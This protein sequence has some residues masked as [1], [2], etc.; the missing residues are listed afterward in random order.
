MGARVRSSRS[1]RL[2]LF[3]LLAFAGTLWALWCVPADARTA[4]VLVLGAH[5][6]VTVRTDSFVGPALPSPH[7]GSS[8][9]PSASAADRNV[10][11]ELAR[12][13]RIRAIT[14]AQYHHYLGSFNSALDAVFHQL[15]GT[16]AAELEAVIENI[17][18]IAASG[19]LWPS[20]LRV[21]FLTLD[22]NHDWW[23]NGPLLDSGQI[24]SFRGSEID[25]EYYPGQGLELQPLASFGKAQ[26]FF[27]NGRRYYRRGAHLMSEL[28]P[29]AANRA[30]GTTW[31]YYFYF[32]GGV[33]PWT[34]AMS[35]GTALQAL[36][37]GY[38][39]LK[40]RSYLSIAHRAL[41]IFSVPPPG[42][43]SVR[44]QLGVRYLLYSFAPGAAVL[45]GFLQ[46]LIGLYDYAHVSRDRL[47]ARLFA[48]GDTEARAEVRNY[49][50]GSW[51][52][53][54]PGEDDSVDYHD[55]VTG[56]LEQLCSYTH[57]R[58]YCVTAAHFRYYAQHPPAWVS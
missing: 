15:D 11:T 26:W 13:Y 41:P 30:G 8:K 58:V 33:P 5:G 24:V 44:T 57:A 46:T 50:T 10:R 45:N 37:D 7:T 1:F 55:L 14:R 42:G 18:G 35:Q 28:V 12:L 31:E 2:R 34:S 27:T 25:W 4:R 53:Y 43:V 51:S 49:D 36:A 29:L 32:D 22:R 16:R 3:S 23:T 48:A 17:H 52:L 20:R 54:Q 38:K 47:A 6:R 19:G 21:L 39:A 56:F 40:N 9:G